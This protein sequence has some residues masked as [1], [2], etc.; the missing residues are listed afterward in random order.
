MKK[1]IHYLKTA[2]DLSLAHYQEQGHSQAGKLVHPIQ[3]K[4][5]MDFKL[6]D[7]PK[8]Q[9]QI[10]DDMRNYLSHSTNTLSPYFM[11]QLF[12]GLNPLSLAGDWLS[13][14]TN[15]TMATY[16]ASPMAT[17]I[18]KE[19]VSHLCSFAGW[20]EGE[21][22]MT[23]GGSNANFIAMLMARNSFFK[24]IKDEGMSQHRLTAFVS[25]EA[26]YSFDKAANMMGIGVKNVRKVK[27]DRDGKM[28]GE[29]LEKMIQVSLEKGE[30]PFFVAATAGTTVLGVY[31]PIETIA[32]ISRKYN[33]WFHVDG[34][35]GASV[36]V[37]KKYR[38]L[39]KGIEKADSL[40]WDTHKML[41]TGLISSFY[42]T[43]HKNGLRAS[44]DGGGADYI[45]HESD[46][47]SWNQGPLSLQC[48]RRV[49]SLKVW[50]MWRGLGDEGVSKHVDL[51][52][53]KADMAMRMIEQTAELELL[54]RPEML[55]ICFRYRS[56]KDSNGVNT[57]IREHLLREGP[58]FVNISTR[59]GETFFRLITAHP[60]LE[61]HHIE[62]LISS[63]IRIGRGIQ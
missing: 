5:K 49:D 34:A 60:E 12:S 6:S 40:A 11:N 3:L 38:H 16:E 44:H 32:K 46:T 28:N 53:E 27:S 31:D 2:M 4:E 14:L 9:D 42:L 18:E 10:I 30:T 59:S 57:K 41:G 15:S 63:I 7:L 37:S 8:S 45:F 47:S 21:G 55:N 52:F 62:E 48:G 1:E 29:E 19:L 61:S 39:M 17:I 50:L 25:E 51:L 33:L 22:I 43:Q 54:Y 36:L 20:S 58:F 56:E 24:T 13:S 35:W 23:T 26:H